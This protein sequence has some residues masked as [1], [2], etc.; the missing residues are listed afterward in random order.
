MI[1]PGAT[2]GILGGGQ[3]GR[4]MAIAARRLGYG[5]V[6]LDP[7][8]DGPLGQVVNRMI[9]ADYGDL[10]AVRELASLSAVVTL[11]FENVPAESLS[12]IAEM[13]NVAPRPQV[14]A[15][16]RHRVREKSFL[17]DHG[18]PVTTF[19][20]ARNLGELRAVLDAVGYPAIIKTCEFGYDGKGQV[21][22]DAP[23][24]VASAW[25][26]LGTNDAIVEAVVPFLS[27]A[28]VICTRAADGRGS[29][30]PVFENEHRHHIL[31]ITRMPARLDERLR[32]RARDMA[33]AITDALGVVGTLAVELFVVPSASNGPSLL[34]NELAP[35]PHNSGHVT[36]DACRTDQFEQHI[37]AICGLPLGSTDPLHGGGAMANLLGDCWQQGEPDWAA[38]L[39]SDPGLKLHLYGKAS[40]APGRKMGHLNL[41]GM[42]PETCAKTLIQARDR[43][44]PKATP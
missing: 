35:R 38:T 6:G 25:E 28:S 18:F 10:S 44:C 34:V 7:Q 1:P 29:T 11:E 5:I 31:D 39:G 12:A 40:P 8:A 37:R 13:V 22:V 20:A 32:R 16:T 14:L 23:D 4:M 3:L 41:A 30:F 21:R 15:T 26:K 42:D 2:I 17:R 9:A 33:L 19:G 36:I 24:E 43:L 27:E